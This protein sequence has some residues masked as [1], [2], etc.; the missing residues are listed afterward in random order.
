MTALM[1]QRA[2]KV[3]AVEIDEKLRILREAM[4]TNDD[5]AAK[6]ALKK[7]VPTF[8]SPENVNANAV[9]DQ[10]NIMLDYGVTSKRPTKG[11]YTLGNDG[12]GVLHLTLRRG[13]SRVRISLTL[14]AAGKFKNKLLLWINGI[15]S[16]GEARDRV[17]MPVL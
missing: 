14:T 10:I 2:K 8:H 7:V 11:T 4:T 9:Q 6:A 5:A 17:L 13:E 15:A 16:M 3:L 12:N 1:A